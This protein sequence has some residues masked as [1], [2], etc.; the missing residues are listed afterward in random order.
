MSWSVQ[1]I[2]NEAM[3]L[4]QVKAPGETLSADQSNDARNTLNLMLDSWAGRRV[5][6]RALTEIVQNLT[7]NQRSYTIGT[8]GSPYFNTTRPMAIENAGCE[9]VNNSLILPVDIISVDQYENFGD[10]LILHGPVRKLF[11][12]PTMPNGTIY[13][14]PIPDQV[15][16]LHMRMV[17]GLQEMAALDTLFT[18]EPTYMEAIKY[19]LAIR[20]AP[21]YGRPV[22]PDIKDMAKQ[23]FNILL[24]WSMPEMFTSIDYPVRLLPKRNTIFTID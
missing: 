24:N 8:S 7:T 12:D 3:K 19:N 16:K 14:Y 6:A 21:E 1:Q 2:I 5:S 20:L 17:V 18:M 15:Y 4:L 10:R 22:D 13:L 23:L 9:Y 11:Y